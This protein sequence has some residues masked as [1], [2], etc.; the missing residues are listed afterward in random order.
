MMKQ[1]RRSLVLLIFAALSCAAQQK[2]SDAEQQELGQALGEAGNSSVEFARVLEAHLN[3]YPNSPQRDELERA[4]VKSALEAND[5]RRILTWGERSLEKNI[6]QPQ[7]LERV[8][9]I[10]LEVE[11]KDRSERALKYARRFE[12]GIRGLQGEAPKN[13]R[14]K[15]QFTDEY[16]RAIGRALT[17]Q[18]RATGNLGKPDE[19]AALAQKSFETYASHESARE[20]ARWLA[21]AGKG[22]ESARR[23]ADAFVAPDNTS[24]LRAK[25]RTL[26]A[27]QYRKEKGTE[28]GLGDLVLEAHDRA[29]AIGAKRLARLREFD[30]N[31]GV[32]SPVDFTVSALQ[33][34]PLKLGSLKG[35]VVI[36]DF[37]ATWCGPCRV[38]HPLYEQV[39]KKFAGAGDVVFIAI[40]TDEDIAAVQPFIE[41]NKWDPKNVYFEDGLSNLL[42]VSSIPTTIVFGKD[43]QVF[44]RMNGFVPERFVDQLTA[45]IEEARAQ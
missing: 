12:E 27:E 14:Q 18:A 28:T 3:K 38:Q 23:Y 25:D 2:L 33:G 40:N 44:S 32:T 45:R 34:E 26:M 17:L 8:A 35:K 16:D 15:A 21:K 5:K 22:L 42:K 11:D 39:K 10:L 37:W 30:P 24:E 6:N 13:P 7:L 20:A 43:G 4:L 41:S 19:A 31:L 29:V 1:T 36:L 9:R